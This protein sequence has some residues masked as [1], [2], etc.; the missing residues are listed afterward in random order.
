MK[1]RDF[2]S[3]SRWKIKALARSKEINSLIKRNKELVI[4]RDKIKQ[5]NEKLS[6]TNKELEKR[7]KRVE[8]ELKKN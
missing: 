5:K 6:I 8:I 7:I 2:F 4:S 1:L 3:R